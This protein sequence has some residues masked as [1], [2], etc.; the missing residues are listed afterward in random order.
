MSLPALFNANARCGV[1]GVDAD[2]LGV[3][4]DSG[5]GSIEGEG[6]GGGAYWFAPDCAG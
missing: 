2:W 4:G 6:G 1:A 3:A 5:F